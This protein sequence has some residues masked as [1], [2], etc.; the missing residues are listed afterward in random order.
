MV[1]VVVVV[2]EGW[3]GGL[4]RFSEDRKIDIIVDHENCFLKNIF[5]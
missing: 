2:M 1:V 5:S 4:L 3:R